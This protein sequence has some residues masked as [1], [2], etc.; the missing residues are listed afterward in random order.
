[1]RRATLG[2]A[3]LFA[4]ALLSAPVSDSAWADDAPATATACLRRTEIRSTKI[5][6]DRNVLFITRDRKTY[7]NALPRQCPGMRQNSAMSFTYAADGKLCTGSTFTVLYRASPST[8]MISYFD[9]ITQKPVTMQGPPFQAGPVCQ[10]G[11]FAPVNPD[12]VQALMATADTSKRSRRRTD[13][14]AV[15]TEA[16]EAAPATQR[17]AAE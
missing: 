6:S 14:D 11:M 2:Y 17:P 4:A 7:N 8:N 15:R 9:P 13:R 5:I 12:E 1:M 10:I 16:V 3:P